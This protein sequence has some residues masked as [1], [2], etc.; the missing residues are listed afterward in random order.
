ML[1]LVT[2]SGGPRLVS[3]LGVLQAAEIWPSL[4]PARVPTQ[5]E[6]AHAQNWALNVGL[7]MEARAYEDVIDGSYL[8]EM[9]ADDMDEMSDEDEE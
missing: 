1:T 8:P 6:F 4:T 2:Q 7:V 5:E 3:L 9:M